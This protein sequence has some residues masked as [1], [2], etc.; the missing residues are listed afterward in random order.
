MQIPSYQIQNVL[1][2]YSKQLSQGR[3][4]EFGN[5]IHYSGKVK[6]SAI[7]E[8]VASGIVEKIKDVD[9]K[10]RRHKSVE[11]NRKKS[12]H[13]TFNSIDENNKKI[14]QTISVE[15]STFVLKR[16]KQ[17]AREAAGE[18]VEI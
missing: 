14:T 10:D 3:T 16:M 1:K 18:T 9:F 13:F 17:L 6:I 8:K 15:N 4:Q 11:R 7:I 2:V 5:D 12:E